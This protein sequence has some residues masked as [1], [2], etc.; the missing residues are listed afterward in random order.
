M[1][2]R[3]L[4][5]PEFGRL[6]GVTKQA[7]AAAAKSGRLHRDSKT[8]R[9]DVQADVNLAFLEEHLAIAEAEAAEIDD[10]PG[11]D[12]N[13]P[14]FRALRLAKLRAEVLRIESAT[15]KIE[16]FNA[17]ARGDVLATGMVMAYASAFGSGCSIYLTRL[18]QRI[19][20]RLV[21]A[22]QSGHP[23]TVLQLLEEEIDDSLQRALAMGDHAS[24]AIVSAWEEDEE[25]PDDGTE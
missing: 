13:S 19:A 7:I 10:D 17:T 25:D 9:Y 23:E 14:S 8:G 22:V 12:E 20:P 3:F 1:A 21:A 2:K 18:P 5:G 24:D 4:N 16:L 15:E 11:A 6:C